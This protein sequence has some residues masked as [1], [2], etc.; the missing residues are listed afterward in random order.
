M[1][2]GGWL[3]RDVDS[4]I[5]VIR[6]T[7]QPKGVAALELTWQPRKGRNAL[8]QDVSPGKTCRRGRVP[9][10]TALLRKFYRTAS[11]YPTADFETSYTPKSQL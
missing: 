7:A 10:G 9:E 5:G 6:I 8:A 4:Q 2:E 11:E 1:P 3:C